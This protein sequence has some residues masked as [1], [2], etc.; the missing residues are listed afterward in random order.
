MIIYVKEHSPL[1]KDVNVP[2]SENK[3]HFRKEESV[4]KKSKKKND[5]SYGNSMLNSFAAIVGA[6]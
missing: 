1:S 5:Y 3:E 4:K 6:V 2:R